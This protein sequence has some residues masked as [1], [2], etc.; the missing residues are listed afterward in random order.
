MEKKILERLGQF[1]YAY[2]YLIKELNYFGFLTLL[3]SFSAFQ[4]YTIKKVGTSIGCHAFL[5]LSCFKLRGTSNVLS[6]L[7]HYILLKTYHAIFL[8]HMSCA[9]QVFSLCN[10]VTCQHYHQYIRIALKF[11]IFK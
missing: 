5:K 3:I 11:Y 2:Y 6:K 1:K 7:K 4:P 8:S 10:S 9:C